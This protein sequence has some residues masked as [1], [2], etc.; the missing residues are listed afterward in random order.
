MIALKLA[1][2]GYA[3]GDPEKVLNMRVDFV[4]AAI[5]YEKFKVDYDREWLELNRPES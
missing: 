3:G 4:L 2:L 5:Q 1:S